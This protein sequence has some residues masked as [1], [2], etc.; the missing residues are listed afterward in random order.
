MSEDPLERQ[1]ERG[2]GRRAYALDRDLTVRERAR[3]PRA[4]LRGLWALLVVYVLGIAAIQLLAGGTEQAG[5]VG[6]LSAIVLIAFVFETL[7]S[8]T[9]MGSGTALVPVL[10]A[11]G[12][13]VPQVVPAV[14]LSETI[15][16]FVA[17]G[18]HQAVE[19]VRFSTA[20]PA[21]ASKLVGLF[22]GVG[23]IGTVLSVA[24]VYVAVAVPKEA[25]AVYTGLV[26]VLVGVI[27]LARGPAGTPLG[28]RPRLL[29]AIAF[30]AGLTK[31]VGGG[32]YGPVLTVGQLVSGVYEK[33]AVA[34]TVLSEAIVS[35]VGAVAVLLLGGDVSIDPLLVSSVLAGG[36]P[37]AIVAPY[38]VRVVP[39]TI[40][41]YA[42]PGYAFVL[43]LVAVAL[44]FGV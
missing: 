2:I 34:I 15:T 26:A 4:I 1:E 37:A 17:G 5:T 23:T 6:L 14:L 25:I 12:Y 8:A 39:A 16:G 40:W 24:I 20:P 13:D 36:V 43:G 21:E 27:G 18:A 11:L 19:N 9:G 38:F 29:V 3:L 30:V 44:G 22:A 35:I 28:Y 31:G 42:I 33:S 10:F 32:G 41:R 7:D